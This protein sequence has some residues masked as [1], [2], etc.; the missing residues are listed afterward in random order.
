MRPLGPLRYFG[1]LPMGFAV[2]FAAVPLKILSGPLA[3]VLSGE[4]GIRD[5]IFLAFISLFLI[6]A[7]APF[8]LGLFILIGRTRLAV[9]HDRIIV[10]EIAGPFRRSRKIRLAD[11]QRLE[12]A[13]RLRDQN[14]NSTPLWAARLGALAVILTN[15]N[16]KL[17]VLGYPREW[18]EPLAQKLS[19]LVG[20]HGASVPFREAEP[21]PAIA[22][23]II[24]RPAEKPANTQIIIEPSATGLRFMIPPLGLRGGTRG[25][26]GVGLFWCF[27]MTAFSGFA[28]FATRGMKH[29]P[30]TIIWLFLAVF[31]LIGIGLLVGAINLG[32]RRAIFTFEGGTLR[33]EQKGPFGIKRFEWHNGDLSTVQAGDSG[34]KINGVPLMELQFLSVAGRKKSLLR[35]RAED[36]LRWLA[37]ELRRAMDLPSPQGRL[38][39]LDT[40]QG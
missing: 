17:L 13:A 25:M 31:W 22:S 35:G 19:A 8:A 38:E 11:I 32:R 12:L 26:L 34:M 36:E 37:T 21:K 7:L 29:K 2:L 6:A 23:N 39:A 33:V 28:A 9:T 15:G 27:L 5:T 40:I 10:T 14:L 18:L 4:G 20:V 16:S 30:P 3:R 1:F 24:E